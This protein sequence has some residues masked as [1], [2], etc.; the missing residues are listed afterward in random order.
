MNATIYLPIITLSKNGFKIFSSKH[1]THDTPYEGFILNEEGHLESIDK[2][3]KFIDLSVTK[4]ILAIFISLLLLLFVLLFCSGWYRRH[5]N[6]APGGVVGIVEVFILY[7]VDSVIKPNIGKRYKSFTPFLL[8]VFFYIWLNNVLGLLPGWANVTGNITVT[9]CL[10]LITF[11]ITNFNA[12]RHYW[13]E[14]FCPAVPKF[15][16][17]IMIPIE[18]IGIMTKPL[19]LM[20]RLFANITSGHIILLS[21]INLAFIFHSYTFG[22]I[23][24]F[25]NTFMITLKLLVS[26]LQ[27]YI[28]TLLSAI[29]IGAATKNN[30]E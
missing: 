30:H 8:T 17:P 6:K 24:V 3:T 21:I 9:A 23:G 19:T 11:F 7:M 16:Y 10:A 25:I 15:L 26:F 12:N 29:Y 18:S 5:P 20:I 14:I 1:L 22:I 2:T 4:N 13:K 28:F 27:A